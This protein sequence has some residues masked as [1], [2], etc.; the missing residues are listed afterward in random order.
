MNETAGYFT[1]TETKKLRLFLANGYIAT[2]DM[3]GEEKLLGPRVFK[4]N[5]RC[6]KL[7]H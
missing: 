2:M 6:Q 4:T 3:T 1:D 7:I 5:L